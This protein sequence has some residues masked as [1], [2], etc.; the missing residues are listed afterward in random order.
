M[1]ERVPH[2]TVTSN[3]PMCLTLTIV[4]RVTNGL[5][6][7]V[8]FQELILAEAARLTL[9]LEQ[10]Q[11]GRGLVLTTRLTMASSFDKAFYRCW[12]YMQIAA[13][14]WHYHCSLLPI[15]PQKIHCNLLGSEEI[16]LNN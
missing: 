2:Q 11:T 12:K 13:Q 6:Y 5:K 3:F 7:L 16:F 8:Y 14:Q 4:C 1:H 9:L 10:V 15:F